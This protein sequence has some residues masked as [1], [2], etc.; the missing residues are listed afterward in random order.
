MTSRRRL[1]AVIAAGLASA[2]GGSSHDTPSGPYG[3]LTSIAFSTP[4]ILDYSQVSNSTYASGHPEA[5]P[6]GAAFTGSFGNGHAIPPAGD[7]TQSAAIRVPASTTAKAFIY[8]K[9]LTS[10]ATGVVQP[11]IEVDLPSDVIS[12]GALDAGFDA[13]KAIVAV[14]GKDANNVTCVHALGFGTLNVTVAQNTTATDGG[15]LAF[16]AT[17]LTLHHPSSTPAGDLTS[18]LTSATLTVCPRQ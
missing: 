5:F 7:V 17:N 9:Q 2:C 6:T 3:S 12:V 15:D 16:A 18:R 14:L 8:V 4:F 11:T 13:A 10:T 1:A